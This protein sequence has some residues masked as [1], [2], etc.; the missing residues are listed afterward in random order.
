MTICENKP[1]LVRVSPIHDLS[2]YRGLETCPYG[3]DTTV[4]KVLFDH[5]L[6]E[7]E[8]QEEQP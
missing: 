3:W 5:M 6:P 2:I 7:T 4:S 1:N 8:T